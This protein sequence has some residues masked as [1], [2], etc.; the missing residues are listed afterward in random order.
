MTAERI[1]PFRRCAW[2][3]IGHKSEV[4][5]YF[6]ER[7]KTDTTGCRPVYKKLFLRLCT[8]HGLTNSQARR[9]LI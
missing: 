7:S 6:V 2:D 8:R 4:C 9:D 5:L 1:I 3:L